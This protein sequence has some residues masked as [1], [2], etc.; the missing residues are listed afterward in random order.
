MSADVHAL[1][2]VPPDKDV[3]QKL[4]EAMEDA[5]AGKIS[6]VALAVVYRDGSTGGSW[7][8]IHSLGSI[9][10]SAAILLSRLTDLAKD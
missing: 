4:N 3:L 8:T 6:M 7:S 1:D 2:T 10:G 5:E 9:T